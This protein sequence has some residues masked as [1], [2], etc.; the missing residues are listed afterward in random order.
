MLDLYVLAALLSHNG[1]YGAEA[2]VKRAGSPEE[3]EA[4]YR[5]E[6]EAAGFTVEGVSAERLELAWYR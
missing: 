6:L 2:S 4:D 5:K 1:I 3:A